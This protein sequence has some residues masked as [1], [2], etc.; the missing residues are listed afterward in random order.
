MPCS[1]GRMEKMALKREKG[2]DEAIEEERLWL[3]WMIFGGGSVEESK[4]K[5]NTPTSF[6]LLFPPASS[7]M[8][9]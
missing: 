4:K 9:V 3:Y 6:G 2:R 5:K 7:T 1:G 8:N